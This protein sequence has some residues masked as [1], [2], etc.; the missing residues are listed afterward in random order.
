MI[1]KK[2]AAYNPEL[3]LGKGATS[4]AASYDKRQK[5]KVTVGKVMV[6]AIPGHY[7]VL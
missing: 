5:I 7:N 3:E 4:D 1:M 6:G 2:K